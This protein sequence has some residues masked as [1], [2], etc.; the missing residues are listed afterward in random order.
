MSKYKSK[1]KL[2]AARLNKKEELAGRTLQA[3]VN[4]RMRISRDIH[5]SLGQ[6]LGLCKLQVSR[7]KNNGSSK[8]NK[9]TES[10]DSAI[11]MIDQSI[12]E[13][14]SIIHNLSPAVLHE[15][16]LQEAIKEMADR[17]R[18]SRSIDIHLDI[19]GMINQLDYMTENTVYRVMQEVMNNIIKHAEAHAIDIQMIRNDEDLTIMIED[20]GVGFEVDKVSKSRG[21]HNIYARIENIDGKVYIDSKKERGTIITI[22]VPIKAKKYEGT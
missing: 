3:E 2:D 7:L 1:Q 21:L 6:Y 19:A 14:R 22:I 16:G 4:E 20:D 11:H 10:V 13:L 9:N 18:Q 15:K 17:M 12:A 5:D 8:I